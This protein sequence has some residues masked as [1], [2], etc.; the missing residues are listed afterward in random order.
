MSYQYPADVKA[1][2][3][4]RA[5]QFVSLGTASEDVDRLAEVVTDMWA[6]APGGWTYEWSKLAQR[7][8]ESGQHYR[9]SLAYGGARFPCLAD[10]AKGIAHQHQLEQYILAAKDF[11]VTFE[12]RVV[13]AR[14]RGQVIEVPVHILS[15][16]DATRDAPV[17]VTTGGVDTYKMDAHQM[18]VSYVLGAHVRVVACDIPGTGELL[19]VPT[20]RAS[21]EVLDQVVAFARTLTTGRVGQ[22]GVS[23]GGYFSAHAGL[24]GA[25]DAAVVNGGPVSNAFA[26]SNI[27]GLLYGMQDILGNAY[28]FTEVPTRD[29]LIETSARFKLDDLLVK[30]SSCP[31][32]V[33]NGDKDVHV[34]ITDTQIFEGR[35]NTDVILIGGGTHCALNRLDLLQPIVTRWLTSHL[36]APLASRS[37]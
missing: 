29:Q 30:D 34:P 25:V 33:I 11:P 5:P 17:L 37:A 24:T 3:S 35:P 19:Q 27:G 15:E 9:A 22:L 36:H 8:A 12:R 18:W 7:Y 10:A 31:M 2:W 26:E 23:F 13:T 14:Y 21:T 32:L 28:G 20:S 1:L 16:R 4:E 6:D